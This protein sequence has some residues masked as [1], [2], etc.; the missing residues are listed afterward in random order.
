MLMDGGAEDGVAM[1]EDSPYDQLAIKQ[2][3]LYRKISTAK[4]VSMLT[5]STGLQPLGRCPYDADLVKTLHS[6]LVPGG[7][8]SATKEE[9]LQ[10]FRAACKIWLPDYGR[11][12]RGEMGEN[13][14]LT[15]AASQAALLLDLGDKSEQYH[16]AAAAPPINTAAPPLGAGEPAKQHVTLRLA[17]RR[18]TYH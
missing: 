10:A 9:R 14:S 6:S 1:D 3:E 12:L 7:S 18:A 13:L 17:R 4:A 16:P 8:S 5:D 2:A 15:Q 11:E